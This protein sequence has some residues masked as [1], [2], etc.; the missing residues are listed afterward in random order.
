MVTAYNEI[1]KQYVAVSISTSK[2]VASPSVSIDKKSES[3]DI[4]TI[5][6]TKDHK[7]QNVQF[8]QIRED[9]LRILRISAYLIISMNAYKKMNH[10]KYISNG[11]NINR[12]S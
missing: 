7:E 9:A 4:R 6:D 2:S 8:R 11:A 5:A 10:L 1:I 3:N 12:K